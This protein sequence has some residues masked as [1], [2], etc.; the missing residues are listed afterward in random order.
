MTDKM[1][2]RKDGP[3]G[4]L[5]FNNPERHNAVSFEMW[6]AVGTILDDFRADPAICVV[7]LTGAGSKAFVSGADISKFGDERATMDAQTRYNATTERIYGAVQAFPKPT[8]AMIRGFCIGGG[9]GLAI[10]C[11]LRFATQGSKFA[12]PAAKLGIGY[13]YAGI[14]R[15]VQTIGPSQTK[16]IFYSARQLDAAEAYQIGLVNRVLPDSELEAYTAK[17]ADTLAG[18]AP[19]TIAAVKKITTEL[20]KPDP[21]RDL[22]SCKTMVEACFASADFIEGRTAFLEKR[23][24]Q[25]KGK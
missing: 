8:I 23:K 18:N 9:L 6:E 22:T 16:D 2:A 4:T 24:P 7:I 15:F 20:A 10:A 21:A 19:L 5:I 14:E 13:G 25:F 3:I 11:D 1:I 17:Y 12:L